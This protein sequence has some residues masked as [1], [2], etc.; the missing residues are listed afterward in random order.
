MTDQPWWAVGPN[1]V[2]LTADSPHELTALDEGSEGTTN[3]QGQVCWSH[4][5]ILGEAAIA[6]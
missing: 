5:T 6:M 1:T 4:C 3:G 2:Y